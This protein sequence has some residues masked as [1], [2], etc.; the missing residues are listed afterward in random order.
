MD[1][2]K[3]IKEYYE[4]EIRVINNLNVDEIN[5]AMNAIYETY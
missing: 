5:D 2:T 3:A 4:R 1:F